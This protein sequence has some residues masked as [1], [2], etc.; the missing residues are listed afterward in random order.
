MSV[1][2]TAH[3]EEL[4]IGRCLR[5]LLHQNADDFGYEVLVVDDASRDKTPYALELFGDAI[6]VL[7]NEEMLGCQRQLI[8][9]S[10]KHKKIYCKS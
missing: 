2:V 1:V 10:K 6:Q 3:N 7:T 9:L 8:A 4:Y 5:S